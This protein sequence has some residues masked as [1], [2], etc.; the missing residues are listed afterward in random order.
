MHGQ[1]GKNASAK[2]KKS[3]VGGAQ[4]PQN[5]IMHQNVPGKRSNSQEIVIPNGGSKKAA[6]QQ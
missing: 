5:L 4:G 6:L 2:L 1:T 3:L